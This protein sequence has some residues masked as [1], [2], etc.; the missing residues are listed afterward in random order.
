[1]TCVSVSPIL[2]FILNQLANY[3]GKYMKE[4]ELSQGYKAMIDD[5]DYDLVT[6]YYDKEQMKW[7]VR[8]TFGAKHIKYA[9]KSVL[10]KRQKEFFSNI[11]GYEINFSHLLMHRLIMKCG[12]DD[13]VDHIDGNGLNNQKSNLRLCT[14][15]QNAQNRKKKNTNISGYKGVRRTP[16]IKQ[17][18][19][20]WTANIHDPIKK[21]NIIIGSYYTKEDAAIAY[22]EMAIKLFGEY[23]L[24]N[25]L[26]EYSLYNCAQ[27]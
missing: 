21:K 13:V 5:E 1:M 10:T 9:E 7:Y 26:S 23:A 6:K 20:C 8:I 11:L 18:S 14:K 16:G 12:P 3:K 15:Q 22:N 27:L 17:G 19:R 24:L 4:I 2:L 25:D